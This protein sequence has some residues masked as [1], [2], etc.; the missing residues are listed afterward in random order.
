MVASAITV[1]YLN[2]L[3]LIK[4]GTLKQ[5]ERRLYRNIQKYFSAIQIVKTYT[6]ERASLYLG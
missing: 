2:Y 5:I 1:H 6:H 4:I 3:C